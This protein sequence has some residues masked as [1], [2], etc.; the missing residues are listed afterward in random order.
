MSTEFSRLRQEQK[1]EQ[2][3]F[4]KGQSRI[5]SKEFASVDDLLRHDSAQNP[6]P[7]EVSERLNNSVAAEPPPGRPWYR[8]LFGRA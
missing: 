8:R 7:S 1:L 4:Q 6:V 2:K 5:E 3:Q